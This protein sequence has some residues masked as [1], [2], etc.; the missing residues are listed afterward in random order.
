MKIGFDG[1]R[2][3]HNKTGLGNYSR[4]LIFLLSEYLPNNEYLIFN[5]KKSQT[6]SIL[7]D[8]NTTEILP[9]NFFNRY[10]KSLWRSCFIKNSIRKKNIEI[11][12]GLSGE[13]PFCIPKNV[14]KIV[15]IHD[16]IFERYPNLYSF[17]D[18]KIHFWKFKYA[19]KKADLVVAISQQ[20]K[21]DIIDFLKI[22]SKKIKVIYQGCQDD[23]KK[24]FEESFLKTVKDKYNLPEKFLLNVGTIEERKNVLSVI[25][26]IKELDI[27]LVI[28]GKKNKDYY[29]KI[30]K[31]INDNSMQ[32]KV[33]FLKNLT[34]E[35]L[36][37][38]Y[39]LSS[40]FIYPSIFE[41]FGIPI[42][43]ALYSKIPV[44]TT[45]YGCFPEA[46]GLYSKYIDPYNVEEIKMAI[47]TILED[48]NLSKFMSE[49]GFEYAQRFN[50]NHLATI[51]KE[52]YEN[53]KKL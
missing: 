33:Y 34:P 19:A 28:I 24:D 5:P 14:K 39:K 52:T 3:F 41:G 48:Q 38:C 7:N 29:P 27:P 30:E 18:R 2:F 31:Y 32:N 35:E 8:K 16:L 23:F 13:I 26:A 44:I 42:I 53:L 12:H 50:D 1:K 49:K 11:Y 4:S 45:N 6:Y 46:G 51:W 25:K 21:K 36:A 40:I 20:T 15:T 43:E 37:V 22:D 17:F 10:F 47:M 9:H